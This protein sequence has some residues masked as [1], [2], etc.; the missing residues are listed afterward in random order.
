MRRILISALA[1]AAAFVPHAVQAADKPYQVEWVYHVKYGHQAEWWKIFQKYQVAIL[2]REKQLGFV[3]DYR[4]D[5]PGLHTSEDARWDYRIVITYPSYEAS[6]HEGEVERQLFPD[7]AALNRDENRRW[8][9][10]ANHWD[11]PIRQADPHAA[12]D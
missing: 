10:T 1:A 8:E 7:R 3:S 11:L 5:R 12:A 9:L 6:Q 4:I 2:D